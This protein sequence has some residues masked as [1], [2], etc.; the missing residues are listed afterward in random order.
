V[1]TTQGTPTVITVNRPSLTVTKEVSIDG[2]ST[3]TASANAPPGTLLTYRITASNTGAT[4][5]SAVTFSDAVPQY[6]TYKANSGK[7]AT[8]AG[9]AYTAATAVADG[10][11]GYTFT[12]NTV[13]YNPGGATGTVAG[14]GAL[15]LYFQAT[16]N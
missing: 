8:T 16:I 3:F 11:G 9:T 2:G 4:S 15:V 14:G 13:A 5:A 7:F 10:S 6:L 1:I 12:A